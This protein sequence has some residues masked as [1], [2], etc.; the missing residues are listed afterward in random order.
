[1][2]WVSFKDKSP[3]INCGLLVKVVPIRTKEDLFPVK[4]RLFYAYIFPGS[5]YVYA[6]AEINISGQIIEMGWKIN[7][8]YDEDEI[9]WFYRNEFWVDGEYE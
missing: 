6:V 5:Y 7:K 2:E 8:E 4:D 1:M 9:L 3:K